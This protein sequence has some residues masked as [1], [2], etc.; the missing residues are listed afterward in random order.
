MFLLEVVLE[1]ILVANSVGLLVLIVSMLSRIEIR[2]EKHI[3][4]KFFEGMVWI[5]FLA[6]IM[7]TLTFVIDEKPGVIIHILQHVTNAYLF[8]ASS[9]VGILWVLFVDVR[10]FHSIPRIKK[11]LKVLIIPYAIL[12]L[13]IICDLFGTNFIFS[14]D[15][16]NK[17][18]RGDFVVFSFAFVY[19]C[20]AITLVLAILA[21]KRHGH[22][23]FFPVHYFIIPSLLGTIAQGLFYGLSVGWLC[24]SISLL[25][26]QL[27]LANQNAC[28][29]ELSG[30]Y[31][32]KYFGWMLEKLTSTKKNRLIGAIMMDVDHFKTINDEFGHSVG[33]DVIQTIG[34]LLSK[35]NTA[36]TIAFRIGGDEFVVLH[37]NH[38]ETELEQLCS[39]IN[40]Q[41]SEFNKTTTKPY[42][43]SVSMAY[44]TCNTANFSPDQ[45]FHQLD[46]K[47]YEQKALKETKVRK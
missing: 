32:R 30:L 14:I 40:D 22:I 44:S 19:C 46:L 16:N 3:S 23:R 11:W 8:L 2:K 12:I 41:V 36:S 37:V 29:D 17:Y 1:E 34:K 5:T 26:I 15:E 38:S 9:C 20:Y 31:N 28:E 45:F 21:V 18:V 33:D 24:L 4:G 10:I 27:H 13:F 25:F 6:L 42:S 43:L 47:M 35:I 7:E 39:K